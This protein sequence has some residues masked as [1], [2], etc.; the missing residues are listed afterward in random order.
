MKS[1]RKTTD[2]FIVDAI[3]IHGHTYDYSCSVYKT[4]KDKIDIICR[5]HGIFSQRPNDHLSGKGC[6]KCSIAKT[7][8]AQRKNKDLF[9]KQ[10]IG[11]H[12]DKYDYSK[13]EYKSN[14]DKVEIICRY[15]GS[16]FPTPKNHLKGAICL[17]CSCDA[18]ITN[19][20]RGFNLFSRSG[21]AKFCKDRNKK[22]FIYLLE[23]SGNNECFYKVG[24][25]VDVSKRI[26]HI[27]DQSK[28]N[29]KLISK[30]PLGADL[31]RVTEINLHKKLKEFKYIPSCNF[32]GSTECFYKLT[33]EVKD[34]FGV[35]KCNTYKN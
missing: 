15:H 23:I 32:A 28:M 21:Y 12:G 2:Q 33:N 18:K 3:A 34:F 22:P 35:N 26:N 14:K 25:S 17:K 7:C 16:F 20:R 31:S 24:L 29:V 6:R 4:N 9:V 5:V 10:A 30:V 13:V 19:T 1:V 27:K 8:E 11:V